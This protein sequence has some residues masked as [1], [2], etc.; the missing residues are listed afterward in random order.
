MAAS[1]DDQGKITLD[2]VERCERLRLKRATRLA[3]S[4]LDFA[5][6]IAC[7]RPGCAWLNL[8][9]G[10]GLRAPIEAD[11]IRRLVEWYDESGV[12]ARV[13]VADRVD[14]ESF[15]RLGDA[16]FRLKWLVS[17][18]VL[19]A[20][21]TLP[22]PSPEIPN[23]ELRRVDPADPVACERL[24]STIASCFAS[25]DQT[26]SPVDL[27]AN[28]AGVSHP[29][30][31]AIGAYIDGKCAGGGLLD[32]EGDLACL[33]GGAVVAEFRRRG[34]QRTLLDHRLSLAVRA[35]ATRI[36][37][38]T[39]AGGPTHRNAARLGFVIAYTRAVLVRPIASGR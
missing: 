28:V 11:D 6:G 13:E 32:V 29:E 3:E 21:A 19:D 26:L 36:V 15:A 31:T 17:V 7:R 33:W 27:A 22:A 5:G 16:G 10:A 34:V 14:N 4:T 12:P 8:A 20:R 25:D 24:G 38:E 23:L 39:S 37:I 30:A 2:G 18:L 35:G 1:F 9:C